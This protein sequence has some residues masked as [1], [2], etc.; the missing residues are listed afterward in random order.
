MCSIVSLIP[1]FFVHPFGY[2]ES[3]WAMD[4]CHH[5]S[6]SGINFQFPGATIAWKGQVQP[7]VSLSSTE[8]EFLTAGDIFK[9]I[10]YLCSI[11]DELH[12]LQIYSLFHPSLHG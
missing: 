8:V 1:F 3:D 4:N 6:I 11:L 12:G 7:T 2:T 10:I 5:F 9:I